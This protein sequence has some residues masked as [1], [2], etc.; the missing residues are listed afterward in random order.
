MNKPETPPELCPLCGGR[1]GPGETVFAVELGFGVA[2]VRHVPARVCDT[3][4]ESW[5]EDDTAAKLE[6]MVERAR[7]EHR[8]VEVLAYSE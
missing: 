5:I 4:G 7:R 6:Q 2:V 3:C 8:Q 1:T